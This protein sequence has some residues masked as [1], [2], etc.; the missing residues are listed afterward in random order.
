MHERLRNP[1]KKRNWKA[2]DR[3]YLYNYIIL[4]RQ[5]FF[6]C[7]YFY[8]TSTAFCICFVAKNIPPDDLDLTWYFVRIIQSQ[9]R[10]RELGVYGSVG[11]PMV[12]RSF[13][14]KLAKRM[15]AES[16]KKTVVFLQDLGTNLALKINDWKMNFLLGWPIFSEAMLVLRRVYTVHCRTVMHGFWLSPKRFS[17]QNAPM[18][19]QTSILGCAK[20]ARPC[21]WSVYIY[22]HMLAQEAIGRFISLDTVTISLYMQVYCLL[23]MIQVLYIYP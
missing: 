13:S 22:S 2:V 8:I 3:L 16:E 17:N 7:N 10:L 6:P 23:F 1:P 21:G 9:Q 12:C 20:S 15:A 14:G 11:L 19:H 18:H 4:Y 5:N